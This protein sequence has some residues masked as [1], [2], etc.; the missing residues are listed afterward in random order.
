MW[1]RAKRAMAEMIYRMRTDG[2]TP[3]RQSLAVALGAFVGATPL[4]GLHFPLCLVL[5]RVLRLGFVPMYAGAQVSYPAFAPLLY[6]T[7]LQVGSLVRTGSWFRL[8]LSAFREPSRLF[9]EHLARDFVLDLVLGSVIVGAALAAAFGALTFVVAT[10]RARHPERSR[11]F[12]AAARPYLAA[13]YTDWEWVRGKLKGDPFF[14]AVL[15][16]GLL[17]SNATIVDIG[18]GRGI[19]FALLDAA[20]QLHGEKVWPPG[21]PPPPRDVVMYGIEKRRRRVEAARI[22]LGGRATIVE[23]DARHAVIPPADVVTMIDV[24]HYMSAVEADRAIESAAAALTPGGMLVVREADRRGGWR[25]RAISSTERLRS[26]MRG[27]F[28]QEFAFRSAAE[29]RAALE[30]EGLAVEERPMGEGTP[31]A[32]VLFLARRTEG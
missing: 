27:H 30:R 7:E 26:W 32:N 9:R 23:E 24:L 19:L 14:R 8:P 29:W 1:H 16:R 25:F 2:A 18:C 22:A 3:V 11:L 12:E 5:A 6:F 4:F 20:A 21:W 17:P 15:E 13:G 10:R 28:G 31:F